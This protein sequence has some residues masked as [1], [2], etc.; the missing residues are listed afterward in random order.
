VRHE[1]VLGLIAFYWRTAEKQD[2]RHDHNLWLAIPDMYMSF[3]VR[4]L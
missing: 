2:N 1:M 3:S 4:Y